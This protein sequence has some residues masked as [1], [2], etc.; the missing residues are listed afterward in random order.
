MIL[1]Y[2]SKIGVIMCY[3]T[4]SVNLHVYYDKLLFPFLIF[5]NSLFLYL[6]EEQRPCSALLYPPVFGLYMVKYQ[7]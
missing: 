5:F 3:V 6:V 4:Q 1:F 7:P 2:A